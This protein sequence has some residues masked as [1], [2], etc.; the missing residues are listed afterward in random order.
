MYGETPGRRRFQDIRHHKALVREQVRNPEKPP[1]RPAER[2]SGKGRSRVL[3]TG[4][5]AT[6]IARFI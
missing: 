5:P 4:G 3:K 1:R 2:V 6:V